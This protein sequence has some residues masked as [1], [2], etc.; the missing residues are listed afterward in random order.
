[1]IYGVSCH[2]SECKYNMMGI[3]DTEEEITISDSCVC[4]DFEPKEGDEN[5]AAQTETE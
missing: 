4:L 5:E 1:M 3:C 2:C